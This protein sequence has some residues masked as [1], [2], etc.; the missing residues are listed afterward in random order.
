MK[1]TFSARARRD[2]ADLASYYSAFSK[3]TALK[4]RDDIDATIAVALDFPQGFPV[5]AHDGTHKAV[6]S[7]YKHVVL[8]TATRD[9]LKVVANFRNQN[10]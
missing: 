3:D 8:Y 9:A 5:R 2:L 7:E 10:R 4:V 1:L 6:T